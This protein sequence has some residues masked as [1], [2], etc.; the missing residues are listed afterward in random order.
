MEARSPGVLPGAGRHLYKEAVSTVTH[1]RVEFAD[2]EGGQER[3]QSIARL[4][5]CVSGVGSPFFQ[6]FGLLTPVL[7]SLGSA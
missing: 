4:C 6:T 7:L 1:R 2:G 5:P 3:V